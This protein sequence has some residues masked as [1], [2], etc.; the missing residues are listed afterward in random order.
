M[1][2]LE[3]EEDDSDKDEISYNK[4]LE[5]VNEELNKKKE[6]IIFINDVGL[7]S[8][9]LNIKEIFDKIKKQNKSKILRTQNSFNSL[10]PSIIKNKIRN[11]DGGLVELEESENIDIHIN[12]EEIKDALQKKK[13]TYIKSKKEKNEEKL[14]YISSLMLSKIEIKKYINNDKR[15]MTYNNI[16][17]SNFFL[18]QKDLMLNIK[19]KKNNL[20]KIKSGKIMKKIDIIKRDKYK[21][22]S[23]FLSNKLLN[24]KYNENRTESDEKEEND[25]FDI[26]GKKRH[27]NNIMEAYY[28]LDEENS[29]KS[30]KEKVVEEKIP[31]KIIEAK[32]KIKK[33]EEKEEEEKK[34][35]EKKEEEKKEE[36]EKNGEYIHP[37]VKLEESIKRINMKTKK[38]KKQIQQPPIEDQKK[39]EKK[40]KLSIPKQKKEI[41]IKYKDT[42]NVN[43]ENNP[44]T[45]RLQSPA[46]NS[47]LNDI[48]GLSKLII[49]SNKKKKNKKNAIKYEKH[50][51][52][53]YWK[54]NEFRKT[55]LHP[56]TTNKR[57]LSSFKSINSTIVQD[58]NNSLL[59]SNFS[60]FLKKNNDMNYKNMYYDYNNDNFSLN[61]NNDN[62]NP[63]S[64]NWTKKML[65]TGY[66]RKI[67]LKKRISGIPEIELMTRSKSSFY[68][69][70]P[71]INYNLKNFVD[72][73][74][75]NFYKKNY[76]MFGRIY[77]KNEVE[78]PFIYKP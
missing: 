31:R 37:L 5:N 25:L 54:E 57:R 8:N 62:F 24:K 7:N 1:E 20:R 26:F 61:I 42:T 72:S 34:E 67:K 21:D 4:Y 68:L 71:K 59:S 63:Y 78:F 36:E 75:N 40:K 39:E 23:S 27:K 44:N 76:N 70:Q 10:N 30:E 45:K 66:N 41:K 3:G 43:I 2:P 11:V 77:S 50:F 13:K 73:K 74:N 14:D 17:N 22:N 16:K 28:L 60:S 6:E 33:N 15:I 49:K 29:E 9:L 35:E 55:F 51:G 38:K 18:K 12:N 64:I 56:L 19:E 32:H 65:E 58:D 47:I 53:E 46:I 48:R 52:Y 69:L